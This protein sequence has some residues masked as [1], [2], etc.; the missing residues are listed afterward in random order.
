M[1]RLPLT[2]LGVVLLFITERYLDTRS[3]YKALVG[4]AFGLQVLGIC[5]SLY[6]RSKA[7]KAM[8]SDEAKSWLYAVM[9]QAGLLVSCALYLVVTYKIALN[10]E[11]ADGAVFK[12]GLGAWV[13]LGILSIFTGIGVELALKSSGQASY[14]EP[15]RVHRAAISWLMVGMVLGSSV[16]F[17]Y[18]A[19]K[20]NKT[21]DLSYLKV[22]KPGESTL[23][24]VET[25]TE[26]MNI[27]AF[28]PATNEVKPYV[29]Q[30]LSAV[31]SKNPNMTL[32]FY[33]KD[34]HPSKAE[35][36]KAATNGQVVLEV[37]GKRE[38]VDVGLTLSSARSTLKKLDSEFQKAFLALTSAKKTVYFTRGHG[39]SS[40]V[41]T[42][43]QANQ[44]KSVRILESM[45]RDQNYNLR[46]W[47]LGE[48]SANAVPDDASV[49]VV[50]GA[51][52]PFLKEEADAIKAFLDK[53]GK[54]LVFFEREVP[55]D[56]KVRPKAA[57]GDPL[58]K[59]LEEVGVKFHA[60]P[61]SHETRFVTATRGP[62]DRWFLG[63]NVFTSHE[64]V[65]SLARNDE[66]VALLF[67]NSG[68]LG[69]TAQLGD[70]RTYETIRTLSDTFVDANK[71]YKFDTGEKKG[72][73]VIGA[74]SVKPIVLPPGTDKKD[75]NA[76]SEARVVV[77][78]D[79]SVISDPL[80]QSPGNMV[81]G[82]D[83]IKWLVGESKIAGQISSE[84]DI[85]IQHTSDKDTTW[86]YAT[87]AGVPLL[88]LGTGF[89]ATRRRKS[90]KRG[91]KH[92]V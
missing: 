91:E 63:T 31:A 27:A 30:Y 1:T 24:M 62:L 51:T 54:L 3:F 37:G 80:M 36:F 58:H 28:F 5:G 86:F 8:Y 39:E 71:N 25:L 55:N 49:V 64:S 78:A 40:W 82:Y 2:V 53:G 52:T 41:A 48:G 69:I 14:A 61:L 45:L 16:G 20:K 43:G 90:S 46:F 17:N 15:Q 4:V 70:W 56:D 68:Y 19:N 66:K 47:G 21:F 22:T 13:L 88:V 50:A 75:D 89:I 73:Y 85:K 76:P 12:V 79:S 33:D 11:L 7:R 74:A 32:G 65:M 92:A 83:A 72:T 42:S 35:Q 67:L 87:I 26:P 77:F 84:E 60:D 59:M 81:L 10:P 29:E 34:I 9:W 23:K 6:V 18:A 38:R 57:D 44:L